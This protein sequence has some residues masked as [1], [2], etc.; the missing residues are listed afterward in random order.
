MKDWILHIT[1][2]YGWFVIA[3]LAGAIVHRL[4][5]L[6]SIGRF[7]SVIGIS[8]FVGLCV[9]ILT[10]EYLNVSEEVSFVVCAVSG[11][12][13]NDILDEAQKLIKLASLYLKKKVEP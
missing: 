7:L 5:R 9:G 3:G 10:R 12:F 4:R 11:V 6:M 1:Q 13:S 2:K 8:I